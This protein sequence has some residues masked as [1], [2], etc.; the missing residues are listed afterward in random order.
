[1]FKEK[2]IIIFDLDGT[3][4][5]S[6]GIWNEVDKK[7]IESFTNN[8]IDIYTIQKEREQVLRKTFDA[9]TY[10][11]YCKYLIDK[12]NIKTTPTNLLRI[13]NNTAS[14][15]LINDIDY[16]ENAHIFLKRLKEKGYKLAIAT[17]STKQEL[18]IYKNKN[19]NIRNKCNIDEI[20]DYIVCSDDVKNKKPSPEMYLKIMNFYSVTPKECIVFE[21]SISGIK[22]A[23]EAGLDVVL[24]YDKYSS[25]ELMETQPAYKYTINNYNELFFCI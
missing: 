9:D 1:M 17:N 2:K 6:V 24:V 14:D 4:I 10:L 15:Y 8:C 3:L 21:D 25:K 20:F 5:D 22:A 18:D 12:Y 19:N 11:K 23:N 13:R 7:I 16:K